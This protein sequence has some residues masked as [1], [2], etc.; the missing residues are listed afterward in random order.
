MNRALMALRPDKS[1]GA[2]LRMVFNAEVIKVI[3]EK[4]RSLLLLLDTSDN[5]LH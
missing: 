3:A 2:D 5:T 1:T 4:Q